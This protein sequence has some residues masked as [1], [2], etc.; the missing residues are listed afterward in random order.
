MLLKTSDTLKGELFGMWAV[1]ILITVVV[2]VVVTTWSHWMNYLAVHTTHYRH[3]A[4]RFSVCLVIISND[5]FTLWYIQQLI[6]CNITIRVVCRNKPP[7]SS[8]SRHVRIL[9]C[10]HYTLHTKCRKSVIVWTT[11]WNEQAFRIRRYAMF[12]ETVVVH[13]APCSP[14]TRINIAGKKWRDDT[15]MQQSTHA[16]P[17]GRML[18]TRIWQCGTYCSFANEFSISQNFKF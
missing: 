8:S 9:C 11:M 16:I 4:F 1:A 14:C 3:T 2:V 6:K 18:L 10:T 12:T 7:P 17:Y 13:S 15:V 5:L